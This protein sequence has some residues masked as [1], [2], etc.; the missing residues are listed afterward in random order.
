MMTTV[1]ERLAVVET[2]QDASDEAMREMR[3]KIDDMHAIL[4]QAKGAR[5][6][7]LGMASLGGALSAYLTKLTPFFRS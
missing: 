6:A 2:K 5:W 7:I 3:V 1:E 4:L